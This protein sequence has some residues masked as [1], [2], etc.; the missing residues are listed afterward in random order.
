MSKPPVGVADAAG[1]VGLPE[2]PNAKG[3][4]GGT[5]GGVDGKVC[6]VVPKANGDAAILG[7]W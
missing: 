1:A 7:Y 4:G 3:A 2:A 6:E 5:A